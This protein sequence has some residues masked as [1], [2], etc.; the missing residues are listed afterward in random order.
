MRDQFASEARQAQEIAWE[1]AGTR[2][3]LQSPKQ[4]QAVL[5]EDMGLKPTKRTKSGSYTTSAAALQDLYVKSVNNERA[6][7]FL[8]A[9]L[10]HRET[11]KLKQIVQT[12]IE[13][14]NQQDGRIHTTYEQ[15]VA[16][17]GRLSSVDPQ[18]AEH[19][20]PERRRT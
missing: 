7:G 9:L 18:S 3:N 1:H 2:V 16:A 8:G 5:F 14:T 12:L 17:T 6:N 20:Q 19:P 4:L 10:R 15:T 11:N 13:A